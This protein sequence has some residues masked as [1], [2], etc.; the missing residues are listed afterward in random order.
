M[1][2]KYQALIKYLEKENELS[3]SFTQ[4]AVQQPALIWCSINTADG[5]VAQL[6]ANKGCGIAGLAPALLEDVLLRRIFQALS[7]P[8]LIANTR[9]LQGGLFRGYRQAATPSFTIWLHPSEANEQ[10]FE[11]SQLQAS[12]IWHKNPKTCVSVP[13]GS[14]KGPQ[15]AKE[16]SNF[17]C[18]FE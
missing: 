9:C 12:L 17:S 18:S 3:Y 13:L 16:P 2:Y 15:A 1:L 10:D 8:Y 4:P 11:F 14:L 6:S 7:P 5:Q